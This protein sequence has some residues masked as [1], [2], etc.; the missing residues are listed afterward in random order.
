MKEFA[1]PERA[2]AERAA[3]SAAPLTRGARLGNQRLIHLLEHDRV[4]LGAGGDLEEAEADA[5]ASRALSLMGGE[6]APRLTPS[7]ARP[8][9][10]RDGA[11][12]G[13]SV[14]AATA[15]RMRAS[16]GAPI[17]A[18]LAAKVAAVTGR[19][20]SGVHAHTG[21]EADQVTRDLS[22]SA[23]TVGRDVWFRRGHYRPDTPEGQRLIAHELAHAA[24][25]DGVARR[26][27][28]DR[29]T[30]RFMS[31]GS[32]GTEVNAT[33]G[34]ITV[35]QSRSGYI[36]G[37]SYIFFEFVDG[38]G[39]TAQGRTE[40]WDLIVGGSGVADVS[41]DGSSQ[42]AGRRS[43]GSSRASGASTDSDASAASGETVAKGSVASGEGSGKSARK[44]DRHASS[45]EEGEYQGIIIRRSEGD[46]RAL[47]MVDAPAKR[48]YVVS[49]DNLRAA[50]DRALA[51]QADPGRY[52]YKFSGRVPWAWRSKKI[53]NC[54]RFAQKVLK[55]A[56]I[57]VTA[58]W[59]IKTPGELTRGADERDLHAMVWGSR[60]G[61]EARTREL[62]A[63]R[64]RRRRERAAADAAREAE[65]A[66]QRDAATRWALVA[67]GSWRACSVPDGHAITVATRAGATPDTVVTFRDVDADALEDG[68]AKSTRMRIQVTDA[69]KATGFAQVQTECNLGGT[70]NRRTL[71]VPL[72]DLFE[73]ATGAALTGVTLA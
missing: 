17:H 58:G 1:S 27:Y 24:Q 32:P 47:K 43:G 46:D 10:R 7:L 2:S 9:A 68:E 60:E 44:V 56:G 38:T 31:D 55:A 5:I 67:E 36:G 20:L 62:D 39:A 8:A 11:G 3:P 16:T 59:L 63:L 42:G 25:D 69:F 21:V 22:A 28:F 50:R 18:A 49:M 72:A 30:G 52:T 73:P 66:R 23:V 37:H 48:S 34:V 35:S 14:P 71:H 13:G 57:D 65:A 61:G 15:A 64:E 70:L 33:T 53:I 19:D 6:A 54:S 26:T 40:Q 29:R 45:S 41:I 12:A 51:I 4:P